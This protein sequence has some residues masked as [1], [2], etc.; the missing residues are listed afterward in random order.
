MLKCYE[1]T[2][3]MSTFLHRMSKEKLSEDPIY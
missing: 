3:L 1:N 2:K